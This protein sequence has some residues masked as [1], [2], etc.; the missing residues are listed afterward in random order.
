ML[1]L[2]IEECSYIV[3][4]KIHM[5]LKWEH[6]AEYLPNRLFAIQKNLLENDVII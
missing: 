3:H 5:K 6:V 1:E 4:F 2:R